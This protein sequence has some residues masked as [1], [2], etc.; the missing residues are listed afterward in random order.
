VIGDGM[1][2]DDLPYESRAGYWCAQCPCGEW[3]AHSV[4]L[5][6]QAL[7]LLRSLPGMG[8]FGWRLVRAEETAAS[9]RSH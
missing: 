1:A 7:Y 2:C 8:P 6:N 4:E 5:V 9:S 3:C